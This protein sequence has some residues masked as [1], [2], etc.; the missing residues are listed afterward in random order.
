VWV[1][2][3]NLSSLGINR[4]HIHQIPIDIVVFAN[5]NTKL[6]DLYSMFIEKLTAQLEA[7]KQCYLSFYKVTISILNQ[8]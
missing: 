8:H 7:I 1:S 6:S 3:A 5:Y 2:K 4:L